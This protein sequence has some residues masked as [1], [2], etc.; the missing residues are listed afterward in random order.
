MVCEG[1]ESTAT[2]Q[3][4]VLSTV[5]SEMRRLVLNQLTWRSR[6]LDGVRAQPELENREVCF[7]GPLSNRYR[8]AFRGRSAKPPVR[9][10]PV[11]AEAG[12]KK[13]RFS[14]EVRMGLFL[15]SS[16]RPAVRFSLSLPSGWGRVVRLNDRN[17]ARDS[18]LE[19]ATR[20]VDTF[21]NAV[22]LLS[23]GHLGWLRNGARAHIPVQNRRFDYQMA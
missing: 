19:G 6:T 22:V 20:F 23:M 15:C 10:P 17:C 7:W 11:W 12:R 5:A 13:G 18:Y 4:D 8:F 21:R 2:R 14:M 9:C 3:E 1:T 16:T